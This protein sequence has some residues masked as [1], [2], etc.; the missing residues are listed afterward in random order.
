MRNLIIRASV[1][2]TPSIQRTIE[3]MDKFFDGEVTEIT[4]G[5][6]TTHDQLTLIIKKLAKHAKDNEF[7]E[8]VNGIENKWQIEKT[9]HLSDIGRDLFW[10]QRAWSRLLNIGEI[11][12]PPVPAEVMFDYVNDGR[13]KKGEIIQISNHQRGLA[14]DFG[15]GKDLTA[16]A[17][18]VLTALQSGECFIKGYRIE[19]LNNC[20]H[21]DT[22][23]IGGP[24]G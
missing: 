2:L 16:K 24:T 8:F 21:V 11:I 20:T 23:Q 4:D 14:V 17:K 22:I 15:G 18:C 19:K 5:F 3:C 13:N 9:V 10:W 6:R 7:S 1:H 12:N